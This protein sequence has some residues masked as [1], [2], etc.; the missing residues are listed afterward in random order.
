MAIE[1][2]DTQVPEYSVRADIEDMQS[3]SDDRKID[4]DKV[5]VCDLKYPIVVMDRD[6]EKQSTVAKLSHAMYCK[7]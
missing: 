1:S 2:A 7:T 3:S 5:G 4:I 6:N